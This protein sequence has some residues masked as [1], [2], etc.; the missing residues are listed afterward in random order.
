MG[1]S[2]VGG[3]CESRCLDGLVFVEVSDSFV[4]GFRVAS[5][6]PRMGWSDRIGSAE[7][8]PPYQGCFE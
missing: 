8:N 4:T 7:V 1:G 3:D 2:L 5:C 6:E